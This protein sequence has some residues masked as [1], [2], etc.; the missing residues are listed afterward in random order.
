ME[1]TLLYMALNSKELFGCLVELSPPEV[2]ANNHYISSS[3]QRHM[4]NC[5][6]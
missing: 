1:V 6:Y 3:V 5:T 4:I 2:D